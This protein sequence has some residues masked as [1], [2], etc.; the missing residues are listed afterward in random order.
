[1]ERHRV[2]S[3]LERAFITA[4]IVSKPFL[5]S[6]AQSLDPF[7][8]A[9]G[10]AQQVAAWCLEHWAA[11][12][13]APGRAI[14]TRF[15]AWADK[16]PKDSPTVEAT[17][18]LLEYLSG[19]YDTAA[20]GLNIPHLTDEFAGYITTRTL[21]R[22][23]QD[24]AAA[25]SAGDGAEA[26]R[27][28]AAYRA[29]A[30]GAAAGVDPLNDTAVWERAFAEQQECIVPF[31]GP[32]G[33]FLNGAFTAESLIGIQAPEKRGKTMW[34]QELAITALAARRRVAFFH[35][36]D[37]TERQAVLRLGVR[38][39]GCPLHPW[40]TG[41]IPVPTRITM[42]PPEELEG[43]PRGEPKVTVEYT[44]EACPNI[45]NY[46]IARRAALRFMHH[47]GILPGRKYVK[48]SVH[49]NSSIN[50]AGID[51]ILQR[52]EYEEGF[53][54]HL[55]LIDY[56][57]ILAPETA[58]KDGR[59][60]VDDTWKALRRLS[61][62]RHCLVVTPTQAK[63][64]AY[65]KQTQ[66]M[67]DFS[68]DKRKNAHVTGMLGLNQNKAEKAAHVM[69]LNWVLLREDEFAEDRCLHVAQCFPLGRALCCATL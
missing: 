14:E 16:Q 17:A 37:L 62:Q 6:A 31:A 19:Q 67:G 27:L 48:M 56:A 61:Q 69:R 8:L 11:Y 58:R 4:L 1:M 15:L 29:P 9:S 23:Q 40:Q 28:V 2:D 57:D 33:K 42:R 21:G 39:S 13:D 59:A 32:A 49:A 36:G 26:A 30:I 10:P 20:A 45:I 47:N 3:Q 68:N 44:P 55:V 22:L 38:L 25:I 18:A 43:L 50:V 52:W 54:P 53:I 7:L 24:I 5:A 41:E 60:E 63:A 65:D 46:K 35:V 34:C 66:G 64:A 12:A 51:A